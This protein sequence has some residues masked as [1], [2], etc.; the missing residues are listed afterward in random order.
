MGTANYKE[1]QRY[2]DTSI[3]NLPRCC[4][5]DATYE[6]CCDPQK[7]EEQ[8]DPATDM[9]P[10]S[11]CHRTYYWRCLLDL[12]CCTDAQWDGIIANAD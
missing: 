11:T 9:C 8:V 4:F 6:I 2:S 3:T 10:C 12:E 1:G 7:K 5:E